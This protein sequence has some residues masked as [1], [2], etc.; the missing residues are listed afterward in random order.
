MIVIKTH[1]LGPVIMMLVLAC[2]WCQ[3]KQFFPYKRK[4]FL[5]DFMLRGVPD[6][7]ASEEQFWLM[8]SW[9]SHSSAFFL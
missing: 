3:A 5:P 2:A 8:V 6:N 7:T 1:V 9:L 4:V